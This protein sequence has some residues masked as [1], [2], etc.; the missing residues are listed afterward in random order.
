MRTN[1]SEPKKRSHR[2]KIPWF[3]FLFSF[4]AQNF[5]LIAAKHAK[6]TKLKKHS[7]GKNHFNAAIWLQLKDFSIVPILRIRIV[8]GSH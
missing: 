6:P 7:L 3:P 5:F 4:G 8:H 2:K 1:V